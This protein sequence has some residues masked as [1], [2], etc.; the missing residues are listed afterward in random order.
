MPYVHGRPE[1]DTSVAHPARVYDSWL[2]GKDNY[3]ADRAM[4]DAIAAQVPTVATMAK[5]NRAFLGRAVRYLVAEAGVRQFLDIGT[6]IPTYGNTHEVAQRVD[7]SARVLYVDNDPI[8]LAH[9]RALMTSTPEG[10][11]AYIEADLRDPA[12]ILADPAL[13]ATLDLDEPVALV[14]VAVLMYFRD[15]P[16][17]DDP[18]GIV[19][20]LLD[21]L[22]AGSHLVISHPTADFAP[23]AVAGVVAVA[24]HG[25]IPFVPR[26]RAGTQAFFRGT[27]LVDPGVVPVLGWR[28]DLVA[29]PGGAGVDPAAEAMSVDPCTAYYWAG[30]GRKP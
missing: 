1:I 9:A 17:G 30:V 4:A 29:L 22:P 15:G 14:L 11:T 18:Q 8:V 10:R 20:T 23:E 5:A 25:G 24:E 19:A 3:A 21:A 26:S 6:G 16:D 28:P 27:E 12:A 7:P 13:A 2:G